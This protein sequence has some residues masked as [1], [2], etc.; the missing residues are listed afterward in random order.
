MI[1]YQ[2]PAAPLRRESDFETQRM[3]GERHAG[4]PREY[5]GTAESWVRA[6]PAAALGVAF[7]A[8]AGVGWLIKRR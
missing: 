5:L 4:G 1:D 2:Q 7:L 3:P 8:G 6:Y